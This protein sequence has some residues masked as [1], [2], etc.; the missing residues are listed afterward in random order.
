ML[1]KRMWNKGKGLKTMF[2]KI[3]CKLIMFLIPRKIL[4]KKIKIII[5]DNK[6]KI[7]IPNKIGDPE[8]F[9]KSVQPLIDYFQ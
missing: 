6:L 9:K 8:K 5:N 2:N 3:I 1:D 4:N 7:I